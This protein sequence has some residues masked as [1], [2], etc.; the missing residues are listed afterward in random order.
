MKPFAVFLVAIS[1]N[2]IAATT[3]DT[4][5]TT[6][7]IGL[8]GGKVDIG[9]N[10]IDALFRECYE[11]GFYIPSNS[12]PY[13]IHEDIIDNNLIH[14]YKIDT[15]PN[16]LTNFKEKGRITPFFTTIDSIANSGYGNH[17]LK[18]YIK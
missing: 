2:L 12:I 13:L 4:R 18:E 16:L 1:D 15:I 6:G 9:E 5:D 17:F 10:P 3:R 7:K 14:W 11:E 8:P